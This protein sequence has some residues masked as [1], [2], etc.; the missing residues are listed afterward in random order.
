METQ[1]STMHVLRI[2][3]DDEIDRLLIYNHK[4]Q[5]NEGNAWN[6]TLAAT[7]LNPKALLETLKP[8]TLITPQHIEVAQSNPKARRGLHLLPTARDAEELHSLKRLAA[9]P[10][11]DRGHLVVRPFRLRLCACFEAE[12]FQAL[13]FRLG[14]QFVQVI[15]LK[16]LKPENPK[17]L[18]PLPPSTLTLH[19]KPKP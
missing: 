12:G 5:P 7:T 9:A 14:V 2:C 11:R 10:G 8:Y 1:L 6:Y 13:R 3:W 17:Q 19:P 4:S 15:R 18:N 16:G